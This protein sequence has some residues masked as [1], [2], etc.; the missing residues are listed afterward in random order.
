MKDE[1]MRILKMVEDSKIT[2]EQGAKLIEAIETATASSSWIDLNDPSTYSGPS[3]DSG[4]AGKKPSW[5]YIMVDGGEQRHGRKKSVRVRI[6]IKL[7]KWALKFVPKSA[8]AEMRKEFGEDFDISQIGEILDE[9][10]V[11]EDLVNVVD[12][13]EGENVRI[14]LR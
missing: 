9:L 11:G 14:F 8:H 10:P 1:V 7:A 13:E 12:S 5:L 2:A 6:P 4:Q 3:T